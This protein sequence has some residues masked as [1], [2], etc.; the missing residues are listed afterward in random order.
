MAIFLASPTNHRPS[1]CSRHFPFA[2]D[3]NTSN[4]PTF[5]RVY[6]F[7]YFFLVGK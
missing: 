7:V 4:L 5:C 2:Q 6:M 1:H 3:A